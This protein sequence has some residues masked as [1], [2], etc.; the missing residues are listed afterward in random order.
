MV[1]VAVLEDNASIASLLLLM[2]LLLLIS[3]WS[4][5]LLNGLALIL[6]L[7]WNSG[8][9]VEQALPLIYLPPILINLLLAL[10]F[11]RTLRSGKT[12]LITQYSILLRRR[13]EPEVIGYTRCVTQ[14]WTGFFLLLAGESLLLAV[15]ASIEIW[16]LF[17]NLLNYI[18]T[19]LFFVGEY[20]F[21]LRY[22]S[23]LEHPSF[24]KFLHSV[25]SIHVS[26]IH[27]PE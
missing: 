26:K 15:F 10:L 14:L 2:P 11:G 6:L 20:L 9:G 23:N 8:T 22:L 7:Q 12:P 5:R 24:F 19:A 17:S 3:R 18:F 21:R 13:L 25:V 27:R 4:L 1:H 16:S